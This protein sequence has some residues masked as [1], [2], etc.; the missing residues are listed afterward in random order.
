[1]FKKVLIVASCLLIL[2]ACGANQQ[3][4]NTLQHSSSAEKSTNSQMDKGLQT[5]VEGEKAPDLKLMDKDGKEVSLSDYAGKKVYL[6]F[7]AS[8]CKP[9]LQEMPHME[10]VYQ[11]FKDD[12]YYAFL[13][14][15]SPKDSKFNNAYA[16][17]EDQKKLWMLPKK[18]GLPIQFCL[19][20][21]IT[22]LWHI[23]SELFQAMSL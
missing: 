16:L 5:L 14:V 11:K 9:C 13:S 23:A 21:R 22:P 10:R 7:W 8:W 4:Q 6:N 17:D 19:I 15:T 18:L 2:T 12:K 1:M 3:K 20:K